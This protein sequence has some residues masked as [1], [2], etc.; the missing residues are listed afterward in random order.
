MAF[1]VTHRV[2]GRTGGRGR[3]LLRS[4]RLLAG[5]VHART[6]LTPQE[7]ANLYVSRMPI[8]VVTASLGGH[9]STGDRR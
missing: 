4:A 9:A 3:A 2:A 1:V 6:T 8:A 7:R 5:K